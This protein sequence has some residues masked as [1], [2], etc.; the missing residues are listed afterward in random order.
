MALMN[1]ALSATVLG[2]SR[3]MDAKML[4]SMSCSV[5]ENLVLFGSLPGSVANGM[6]TELTRLAMRLLAVSLS[7]H[8]AVGGAR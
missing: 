4:D 2:Q 5:T 7:I 1:R 6:M 3:L 8:V